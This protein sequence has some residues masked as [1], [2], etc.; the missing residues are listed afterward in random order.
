MA[1]TCSKYNDMGDFEKKT[2]IIEIL[3]RY[4][5]LIVVEDSKILEAFHHLGIGE[6]RVILPNG[7]YNYPDT[8]GKN[9]SYELKP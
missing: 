9:Q 2:L 3:G 4:S 7:N 6:L 5:N 1:I 8:I